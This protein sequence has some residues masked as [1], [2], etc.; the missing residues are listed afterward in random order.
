MGC[1]EKRGAAVVEH[2]APTG[3]GWRN[4]QSEK[5]H[6]CFGEDCPGHADGRLHDHG[7][8]NIGQ[9]VAD[10]AAQIARAEGAGGFDEF[11]FS[12]AKHLTADKTCVANPSAKRESKNEVQDARS[13]EGDEGDSKKNSGTG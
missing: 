7:L 8:N 4:S 5:A 12:G 3:R 2:R 13:A 6:S 10:D 9:N 11:F 1:I